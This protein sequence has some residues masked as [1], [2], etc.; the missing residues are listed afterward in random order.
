MYLCIINRREKRI[1]FES[2]S[3][4]NDFCRRNAAFLS[5][6][7]AKQWFLFNTKPTGYF[8][9]RIPADTYKCTLYDYI[10]KHQLINYE[11]EH[12]KNRFVFAPCDGRL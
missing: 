8:S 2:V 1:D 9:C 4:L 12:Q 6:Q 7:F 10:V 11:K 3:E 5:E